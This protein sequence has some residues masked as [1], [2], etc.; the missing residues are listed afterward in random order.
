MEENVPEV[1]HAVDARRAARGAVGERRHLEVCLERGQ[2]LGLLEALVDVLEKVIEVLSVRVELDARIVDL[3]AAPHRGELAAEPDVDD[4]LLVRFPHGHH[5]LHAQ[6]RAAGA[7]GGLCA[8]LGRGL[9]RGLGCRHAGHRVADVRG[10][11]CCRP[12]RVRA[13]IGCTAA[14]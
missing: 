12:R 4:V 8:G 2:F 10:G 5:V 13:F 1:T 7:L 14:N 6:L 3:R 11:W 9:G